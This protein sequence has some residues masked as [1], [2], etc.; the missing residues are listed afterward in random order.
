[1]G[2]RTRIKEGE[3][4]GIGRGW[5]RRNDSWAKGE[6]RGRNAFLARPGLGFQRAFDSDEREKGREEGEKESRS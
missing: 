2:G 6:E 3:G 4:R 1:M 5:Q